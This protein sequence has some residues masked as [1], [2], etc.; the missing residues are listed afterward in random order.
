MM[1]LSQ[2]NIM[3]RG[4]FVAV[5]GPMFEHSPWIAE[6]AWNARPFSSLTHLHETMCGIVADATSDEQL[7]L[8][9]AH[10]D[11]V[12]RLA[13]EGKLTQQSTAEQSA[14]GLDALQPDEIAAFERYNQAYRD[15]FGFPFVICA[16]ENKKTAILAAFPIRLQ[17][18]RETEIATALSEIYK[19]AKLRLNDAASDV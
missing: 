10:P 14:A 4:G 18:A 7:T 15:K 17:H 8:I 12:G 11:L 9:R 6:R 3:D 13:R 19:I 2:L 16:R 5:C 1:K